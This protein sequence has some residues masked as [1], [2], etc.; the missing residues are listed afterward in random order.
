MKKLVAA[1]FAATAMAA[2]ADAE[3][4][5]GNSAKVEKPAEVEQESGAPIF[6]GFANY[7]IYSGYQLYGSIVNTE[8][9]LQGYGEVNANLPFEVGPLDDLGYFGGGIW[10]NSDLTGKRSSSYRRAFNE[11]DFNVHW[12]KTFWFDDDK[13]W[14]LAYRTS[15]VWYFYPHTGGKRDGLALWYAGDVTD[16]TRRRGTPTTMDWNHYFEVVNPYLIPYL[17]VVHEYEQSNGNL[18]QFGVKKPWQITDAFSVCP[19]IEFVW[20]NRN[21]NWC[22]SNYGL[23]PDYQKID[24]GLGTMKL[25]LDATYMFADWIGVFAKVAYCQNL[26]PN[27]REAA[28]YVGSPRCGDGAAYGKWN[29]FCWGGVGVCVNF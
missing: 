23:D 4:V 19:F 29:E 20:R 26:D 17:N 3:K 27:L 13:T 21:Y 28:N 22:F 5:D 14:G 2:F 25:E 11:F 7:G 16:P 6:W 24:A 15:F 18:L 10:C 8:P 12:G 9:T 1:A